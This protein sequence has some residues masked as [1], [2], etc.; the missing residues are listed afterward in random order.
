MEETSPVVVVAT[1]PSPDIKEERRPAVYPRDRAMNIST[2]SLTTRRDGP[3]SLTRHS[4]TTLGKRRPFSRKPSSW[5]HP[6]GTMS[7]TEESEFSE[8]EADAGA[9]EDMR[10]E[11]C[12][13]S[14]SFSFSSLSR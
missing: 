4:L 12:L 5:R 8:A 3:M 2:T 7:E 6:G 9:E 11:P 1:P 10:R 14:S 13:H